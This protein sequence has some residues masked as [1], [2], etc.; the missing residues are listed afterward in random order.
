MLFAASIGEPGD[1]FTLEMGEQ[2][3]IVDLADWFLRANGRQE[4]VHFI[5]LRPGEKLLEEVSSADEIMLETPHAGVL[6]SHMKSEPDKLDEDFCI[7]VERLLNAAARQESDECVALLRR[8]VPSFSTKRVVP[9]LRP[10]SWPF[11]DEGQIQKTGEI[12]RSGQVNYWTGSEGRAFEQEFAKYVGTEYAIALSNGTVALELALIA[13]QFQAGGEVIIPS[14]TYVATAS[15]VVARGGIPVVADVDPETGLVTAAH[16]Q[17]VIT[18]R[19]KAIIVVHIGGWPCD[20]DPI[21]KLASSRGVFVIEDCAQALGATYKGRQVGSIGQYGAFS[22]C[23]DKMI[24]SAGEGGFLCLNDKSAWL[25]AWAYKDIGRDYDAVFNTQHPAG[26]RWLTHSWGTNWRMTEVQAGIGRRQLVQLNSWIDIRTRNAEILKKA[27]ARLPILVPKPPEDVKHAF[28]R[29]YCIV[30]RDDGGKSR[31]AVVERLGHLANS[32]TCCEIYKEKCFE[33]IHPNGLTLPN[34]S[35]LADNSL[36]FRVH[37][38][39][40]ILEM[41][42]QANFIVQEIMKILE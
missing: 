8:I 12:L 4:E 23:Q 40:D 3:P 13:A 36:M 5:G 10:S 34:A 20:M 18:P 37:P 26:F 14:R 6:V 29:L 11:F 42:T 2:V 24:T 27:L 21:M 33:G 1:L 22:L 19:T 38:T 15:C 35:R 41:E 28:Y 9:E 39:I 17:A 16:I 32:G 30:L 31:D 25:R 7:Q